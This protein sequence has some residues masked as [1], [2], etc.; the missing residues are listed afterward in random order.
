MHLLC[1]HATQ[2]ERNCSACSCSPRRAVAKTLAPQTGNGD[3]LRRSLHPRPTSISRDAITNNDATPADLYVQS[4]KSFSSDPKSETKNH[5]SE[6]RFFLSPE[7]IANT[8]LYDQKIDAGEI[9]VIY[10]PGKHY[11]IEYCNPADQPAL[12]RLHKS[13][14]LRFFEDPTRTHYLPGLRTFGKNP[15]IPPSTAAHKSANLPN[16]VTPVNPVE[17]S[18]SPSASSLSTLNPQLSTSKGNSTAKTFASKTEP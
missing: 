6:I 18:S 3:V 15:Y 10:A 16:P 9:R 14:P 12:E 7:V 5:K 8:N 2:P 4:E 1:Y 17:N 13:A 11:E